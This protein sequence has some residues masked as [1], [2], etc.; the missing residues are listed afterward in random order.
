MLFLFLPK[1]GH[2]VGNIDVA[3]LVRQHAQHRAGA[4]DHALDHRRGGPGRSAQAES[5]GV[6][7]RF[8][9][10]RQHDVT[11]IIHGKC[12]RES[13]HQRTLVISAFFRL[14]GGTRLTAHPESLG[15]GAATCTRRNDHPQQLAHARAGGGGK[16][17]MAFG[18]FIG[19]QF[20]QGGRAP[21]AAIDKGGIGAGEVQRR[22]GDTMA[23]GN[24]HGR[25]AAPNYRAT[26]SWRAP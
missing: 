25:Y 11:G 12:G 17:A 26:G 4:L 9:H 2:E 19:V 23:V 13:R 20:A 10:H 18:H 6:A 21:D 16:D 1:Q 22:H 15:V 5:L 8:I 24:G 14:L 3:P 7:L